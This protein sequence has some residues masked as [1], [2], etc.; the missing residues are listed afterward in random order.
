MSAPEPLI[1]N[2]VGLG[3]D[4][5]DQ[6][7]WLPLLVLEAVRAG[8]SEIRGRTFTRCALE[9]PAVILPVDGCDFSGCTMGG[10]AGHPRSL[11]FRPLDEAR[12]TGTMVFHAC[13]FIDCDFRGVGFTGDEAFIRTLLTSLGDTAA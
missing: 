7:I 10:I 6:Q 3:P 2:P 5:T 8:K 1:L 9:G 4:H 13:R 12:V 11:L